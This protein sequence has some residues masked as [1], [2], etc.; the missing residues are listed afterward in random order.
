MTSRRHISRGR[1]EGCRVKRLQLSLLILMACW[2]TDTHTHIHIDLYEPCTHLQIWGEWGSFGCMHK[3]TW[4]GLAHA[5]SFT[6]THKMCRKWAEEA[7]DVHIKNTSTRVCECI[8]PQT[9]KWSR[10][11]SHSRWICTQMYAHSHNMNMYSLTFGS[12]VHSHTRG[13]HIL[14][15]TQTPSHTPSIAC[16]RCWQEYCQEESSFISFY[17]LCI[18]ACL[19]LYTVWP[20]HRSCFSSL[21]VPLCTFL[22]SFPCVIIMKLKSFVPR[23]IRRESG[24][25]RGTLAKIFLSV[26]S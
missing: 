14:Y 11:N 25:A 16:D 6:C 12:G 15:S 13:W 9:F 20:C 22:F 5:C 23:E 8:L 17:S 4:L 21:P 19:S 26:M 10:I 2:S 3:N 24:K 18:L 7:L 1:K